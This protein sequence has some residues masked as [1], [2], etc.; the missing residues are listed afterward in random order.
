MTDVEGKP[1]PPRPMGV[2]G[3][4]GS[5]RR[6]SEAAG[7]PQEIVPRPDEVPQTRIVGDGPGQSMFFRNRPPGSAGLIA[8]QA[9]PPPM[10]APVALAPGTV[11]NDPSTGLSAPPVAQATPV[12]PPGVIQSAASVNPSVN[13]SD[14][15]TGGGWDVI[16]ANTRANAPAMAAQQ[17]KLLEAELANLD[18]MPPGGKYA[19]SRAQ[20]RRDLET[21]LAR[22][23]ER[24]GVAQPPVVELDPPDPSG[25]PARAAVSP[26]ATDV[27]PKVTPAQAERE[28]ARGGNKSNERIEQLR[29]KLREKNTVTNTGGQVRATKQ[30]EASAITP[31]AIAEMTPAEAKERIAR[32]A[33]VLT[34]EQ[35]RALYL[36]SRNG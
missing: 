16:N 22:A 36:R 11:T 4:S 26:P 9:A 28:L 31:R 23:R 20:A 10:T 6:A 24:A 25:I 35:Y 14:P 21:L 32:L 2:I 5:E 7:I 12:A 3:T 19:E 33:S 17:V 13:P 15:T 30:S 29:A 18:K 1:V 8:Q 34:P 27:T